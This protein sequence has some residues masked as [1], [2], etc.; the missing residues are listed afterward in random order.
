M[1]RAI[2]SHHYSYTVVYEPVKHGGYQVTVPLL[3]GLITYG[4]DFEEA[5]KMAR[6]AIRCHIQGLR[7]EKED[8]PSEESLLQEKL[9]V[10]M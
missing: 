5:K 1:S 6:D 4:R 8:P 7:K 2:R 3:P 10:S 9:T